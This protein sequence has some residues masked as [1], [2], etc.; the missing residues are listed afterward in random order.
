M[1]YVCFVPVDVYESF[2]RTRDA[3]RGIRYSLASIAKVGVT[4][5]NLHIGASMIALAPVVD[6]P[7]CQPWQCFREDYVVQKMTSEKLVPA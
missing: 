4:N 5:S 6:S 1:T 7:W 2:V 3:S